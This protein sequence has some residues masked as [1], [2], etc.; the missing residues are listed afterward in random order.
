MNT[1]NPIEVKDFAQYPD[2]NG[3]ILAFTVD[4]LYPKP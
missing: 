3:T 4:A 1:Q 2:T